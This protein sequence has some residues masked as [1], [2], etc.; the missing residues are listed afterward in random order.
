MTGLFDLTGRVAVVIGAA[1]GGLG[2]RAA[3]ALATQGATVAVADL[4]SQ[5]DKVAE[6]ASRSGAT[7]STHA[8][9]VTSEDS[10]RALADSV[11]ARHG[12]VDVVVNAAGVMLRR[13][14][15]QTSLEEF[16][17]VMRVN[18]S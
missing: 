2:E 4:H 7:A 18:V 15:E 9:D 11:M 13:E 12:R 3:M 6:T 10:V 17:R 14:V 16:E 5:A 1:A 8:V